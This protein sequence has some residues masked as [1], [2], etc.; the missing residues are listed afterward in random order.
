MKKEQEVKIDRTKV[1]TG[2][3]VVLN[4]ERKKETQ[5]RKPLGLEP[6]NLFIKKSRIRHVH[7]K[8]DA[9]WVKCCMTTEVDGTQQRVI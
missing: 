7:C 3:R 2:G 8:V 5:I 1:S 6:A 9:N 4:L